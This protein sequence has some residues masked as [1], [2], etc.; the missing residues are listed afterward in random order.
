[1][2]GVDGRLPHQDYKDLRHEL[3]LCNPA[4]LERPTICVANKMDLPEAKEH[5]AVFRRKTKLKPIEIS[6]T[7]GTGMRRLLTAMRKLCPPK[8]L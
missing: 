5:L 1:M 7:E 2:A 8:V 6:A 3:G 4:L